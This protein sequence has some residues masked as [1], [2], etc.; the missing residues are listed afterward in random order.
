[1]NSN[2]KL[3][4]W[5]PVPQ[6][7]FDACQSGLGIHYLK[8]SFSSDISD[9]LPVRA[10]V[11]DNKILSDQ[12]ADR[13]KYVETGDISGGIYEIDGKWIPWSGEHY[14]K[15]ALRDGNEIEWE[16]TSGTGA[17]GAMFKVL[18]KNG[19]VI[20]SERTGMYIA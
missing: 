7:V 8:L 10:W 9:E 11:H 20:S 18:E 1:M 13:I 19:V 17:G 15:I 2:F 4:K 5:F 3:P 12:E 6:T 16:I 14:K